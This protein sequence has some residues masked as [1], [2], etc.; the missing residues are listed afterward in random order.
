MWKKAR[1]ARGFR[2]AMR[3]KT[4]IP[5]RLCRLMPRPP[6]L[7]PPTP[8]L[9]F[10]PGCLTNAQKHFADAEAEYKK[11]L[12]IDPHSTE[13]AIGLTNIYMKSSRLADAEPLLRRLAADRPDDG[14]LHLQLGRVLPPRRRKTM[15]S[16]NFKPP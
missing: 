16:W 5:R 6:N 11:V 8:S 4:A 2:S 9:I 15:P 10:P 12:A 7:L 13:A 3:L 1:R 14:G